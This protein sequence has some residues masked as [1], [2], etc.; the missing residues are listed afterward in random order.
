MVTCL[1]A[2]KKLNKVSPRSDMPWTKVDPI[3]TVDFELSYM[4]IS[5]SPATVILLSNVIWSQL[6]RSMSMGHGRSLLASSYLRYS[7]ISPSQT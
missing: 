7:I 4:D 1:N 5:I 3:I 2:R 6:A